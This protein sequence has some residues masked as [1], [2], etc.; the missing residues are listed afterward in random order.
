[1][2][3]SPS[4]PIPT[5]EPREEHYRA[6][7]STTYALICFQTLVLYRVMPMRLKARGSECSPKTALEILRR[8]QQYRVTI[9]R[10]AYTGTFK[11]T[12]EQLDLFA[13]L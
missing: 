1:M 6:V 9:G 7:E 11:T 12:A 10:H 13:A 4:L 5:T 2:M 8:I 3:Q